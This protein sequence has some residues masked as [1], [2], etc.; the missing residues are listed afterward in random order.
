MSETISVH[1]F[2]PGLS[3]EFS[4]IEVLIQRTMCRPIVRLV[5]AKI[6]SSDK[7]FPV[8]RK[9]AELNFLLALISILTTRLK[10]A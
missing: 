8:Q 9:M 10:V 6:R 5:D 3:L 7:D 4:Y 2:S 1:M